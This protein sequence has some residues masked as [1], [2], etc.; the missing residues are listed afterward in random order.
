MWFKVL[1][2]AIMLVW[3]L[4][5]SEVGQ[6]LGLPRPK[7]RTTTISTTSQTTEDTEPDGSIYNYNCP[8][9]RNG[10]YCDP[11]GVTSSD[12]NVKIV[13]GVEAIPNSWP[14]TVWD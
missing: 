7:N 9:G 3:L 5:F 12:P 6:A 13:G 14:A 10:K 11:C 8:Y 1:E 4:S 2:W